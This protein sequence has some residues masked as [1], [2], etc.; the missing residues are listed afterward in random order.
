MDGFINCHMRRNLNNAGVWKM[1]LFNKL[2]SITV[3]S[4]TGDMLEHYVLPH[5]AVSIGLLSHPH[6]H[7]SHPRVHG[8]TS[9]GTIL[10]ALDVC[11]QNLYNE[12]KIVTTDRQVLRMGLSKTLLIYLLYTLILLY[13]I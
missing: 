9:E 3:V 11:L 13:C 6:C 10:F 4:S 7:Q 12:T 5:Q 2:K 1:H 8:T